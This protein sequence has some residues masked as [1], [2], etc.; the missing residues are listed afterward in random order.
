MMNSDRSLRSQTNIGRASPSFSATKHEN[1]ANRPSSP[2]VNNRLSAIRES[3]NQKS[4][5]SA[6]S[7]S[8]DDTKYHRI[9]FQRCTDFMKEDVITNRDKFIQALHYVGCDL[10]KTTID[11]LWLSNDEE[12]SFKTFQRI[13]NDE[14]PIDER[15]L[16]EAFETLYNKDRKQDWSAIDYDRFRSDM[17]QKGDTFTEEEFNK[18][19]YLLGTESG[20]VDVKKL[21]KA[22]TQNKNTCREKIIIE[23]K[24][25]RRD[26]IERASSPR[27]NSPKMGSN[28]LHIIIPPSKIKPSISAKARTAQIKGAFF[29]E[30]YD[31]PNDALY[32]SIAYS[33][34]IKR[35]TPV[36]AIVE[37]TLSRYHKD[38]LF[39]NLDIRIL[40]Y[41]KSPH[42]EKRRLID[43]SS[44]RWGSKTCLE[45]EELPKGSY[46]L[47]PITLGG[48]LR[49]RTREVNE[50]GKIK[51]LRK[52]KKGKDFSMTDDYRQAL[53]YVFDVFD[54]DD[55]KQLDRNEYNLWTLRITGDEISDQDWLSVRESVN[56]DVDENVS[57]EK[58]LKL[59]DYEIQEPETTE[60]ELW[61]GLNSVGFNYAM[62]LDM[63][64]PFQLTVHVNESDIRLKPTSFIELNEIR[65]SLIQFLKDKSDRIQL[66]NP[67]VH[68]FHYQDDYGS[69]LFVQNKHSSNIRISVE[70]TKSTNAASSLPI[71]GRKPPVIHIRQGTSQII[72]FTH[73]LDTNLT[74]EL[75]AIVQL[76]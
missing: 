34:E 35:P 14:K 20:K 15:T 51:T 52:T 28:N 59:N 46:E 29:C 21:T 2:V 63:M 27:P 11:R 38:S 12:I 22:I 5:W 67:S 6:K 58:F 47:V 23:K 61:I 1:L 45:S 66:K 76:Q 32:F 70:T 31:S 68:C 16:E 54:L 17:L 74:M 44:L 41:E 33:F 40:L 18:L 62:E 42:S 37:P 39:K 4:D 13:L 48:V 24:E 10:P 69:I 72:W 30:Y 73:R 57:K 53:E 55:N 75:D 19:R 36:W 9:V 49:P 43:I 71:G 65:G 7:F 25:Q 26:E 64:C 50:R 60:Q 8:E 56:L 3:D